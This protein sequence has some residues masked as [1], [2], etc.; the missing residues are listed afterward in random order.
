MQQSNKNNNKIYQLVN[1]N[2]VIPITKKINE[3]SKEL[4]NNAYDLEVLKLWIKFL[5]FALIINFLSVFIC[6]Y[7]A[8]N[9]NNKLE[10]VVTKLD[11][12]N[13]NEENI[14]ISKNSIEK[15]NTSNNPIEQKNYNNDDN[16]Q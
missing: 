4:K 7:I 10:E 5:L 14:N 15:N 11:N 16:I 12:N 1:K 6:L 13:R 8:T 9:I 2:I 3:H